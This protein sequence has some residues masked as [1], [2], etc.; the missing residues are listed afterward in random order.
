MKTAAARMKKDD[1]PPPGDDAV[2]APRPV[3]EEPP[4]D[5][6]CDLVLTG[7]V[8]SGVVYPWAIVELARAFRFRNIG[9]TSV[10]AIAA[11]LAAAAEYGRRTGFEHPFEVLRRAPASLAETQ[12]DGRTRMLSLFQTNPRGQR[13]IRLW[14]ALGRGHEAPGSMLGLGWVLRVFWRPVVTGAL[15]GLLIALAAWW[16]AAPSW[17]PHFE[18]CRLL[19]AL[20]AGAATILLCT[21]VAFLWSLWSDFRHGVIANEYGLCKG[22][23]S[24]LPAT[25]AAG[26]VEWLHQ[27]IQLSAGLDLNDDRP[28]TFRDLWGAPAHPGAAGQACGDDDAEEARAINLQ[29]ITTNV[30]HGRPYRLPLNDKTSR[31]FYKR[32]ELEGYFPQRVLDALDKASRPYQPRGKDGSEPA[33]DHASAKDLRELPGADLPIVV[34]ARLSLSYPLLFSAVPLWAIDYEVPRPDRAL[35][36]AVLPNR[37]RVLRR[38]MF[39]DGGVSSNFPV[40]LFDAAVPRRP[41]FGLWLD[42]RSPYLHPE[43]PAVSPWDPART[44]KEQERIDQ[45]AWLPEYAEQ[46]RGDSWNRFDPGSKA[47]AEHEALRQAARET[48]PQKGCRADGRRMFGFLRALLTSAT[49]WRDRTS[50]R[51]PHVR[52]RV[53]RLLL[54][55]GEGGLNIGMGREQ[56]LD[57]AHRYGTVAGQKFV[58]RFASQGAKSAPAWDQQRWVRFNLLVNGLRERLDGLATAAAWPAHTVPLPQ[59]I[60]NATRPPGPVPDRREGQ[61]IDDTKA[62]GLTAALNEL[63]KL[64]ALLQST[65]STYTSDPVPELR[66]RPPL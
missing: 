53:A 37:Q 43:D 15:A 27:G 36:N 17:P 46:G 10:G 14:G 60:A 38:C 2:P 13:L 54:R 22:G 21:V 41:T 32:A 5:R 55:P 4:H 65:P 34:A 25:P 3:D 9:G 1:E 49:D 28:L 8:A 44:E 12:P 47:P 64:E 40:H 63:Q 16:A 30:T 50:F 11:A 51:M 66:L 18:G 24:G 7:G 6:F 45:K 52:N 42:R 19:L 56:I 20:P 58:A 62:K 35:K 61:R 29:M 59:A 39:S 26:I 23:S 33:A 48:R 57:M 31:L